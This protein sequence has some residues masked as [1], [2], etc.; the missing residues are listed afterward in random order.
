MVKE[1]NFRLSGQGGTSSLAYG[2][3]QYVLLCLCPTL[4]R[5]HVTI[6][7]N[8]QPPLW[9]EVVRMTIKKSIDQTF[10]TDR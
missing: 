4:V 6:K 7:I 8:E 3:S 5:I 10:I 2:Q 9:Q 1:S